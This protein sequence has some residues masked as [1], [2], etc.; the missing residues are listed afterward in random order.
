MSDCRLEE[1][2]VGTAKQKRKNEVLYDRKNL[3]KQGKIKRNLH[4][5]FNRC[6]IFRKIV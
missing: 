4:E 5:P 2:P 1:E 3:N 6:M